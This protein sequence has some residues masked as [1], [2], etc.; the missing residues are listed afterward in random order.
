MSGNTP[1]TAVGPV[2]GATTLPITGASDV[3]VQIA[4]FAAITLIAWY[5]ASRYYERKEIQ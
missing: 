4:A 5:V 2:L 3:I 1:R